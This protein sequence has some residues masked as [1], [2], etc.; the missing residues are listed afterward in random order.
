MHAASRAEHVAILTAPL[1]G[2]LNPIQAVGA[3]LT[4]LGWRVSVVHIAAA[5]PLVTHPSIAFAALA[6]DS[7]AVFAA[8]LAALARPSGPIGLRRM[9]RTT[10]AMTDRL[11]AQAPAVLDRIGAT[12][13]LADA[14]EPAGPLIARRLGL[15]CAIALTGLPLLGDEL[16][17]PPYVGWRFR[18]D[19]WGRF[20]NRSG[21]AVAR[22]LMRP[23]EAVVQARR[24]AWG[25][26]DAPPMAHVQ[27]AQCPREL[28]FP[29]AQL[30][31]KFHYG[32]P[33]RLPESTASEIARDE[34][35]LIFCSLGTLQGARP[36]LFAI[37]AAACAAIGARAV[38][39]HGGGLTPE[40]EAALPGD[41]LV[42]AFWPQRAVLDQCDAAI[43][44]GGFNSVLDALAAGVPI[45]AL[46][47]GFEQPGTAARIAHSGA[48]KVLSPHRLSTQSLAHALGELIGN[49]RYR[50][51]ARR[52]AA[53]MR[54]GD[55]ADGAA[56][57]IDAA[58]T[59][60]A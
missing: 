44:H 50:S 28:D 20:R 24:S 10:A 54:A 51:A 26:H 22:Q 9:I 18:T 31:A 43:L 32:S 39:G 52:L 48:G 45:V 49:D 5:R 8:Y 37:M 1:P 41:P 55:G 6:D 7:E 27:V 33:W 30:P 23:I 12:A 19:A 38:I 2:H 57:V 42:R 36:A 40:E 46:P 53:T 29:R 47:I 25:L 34:R 4:A 60:R 17:P 58:L 15:P 56:A 35:P 11:L 21:Y 3:R 59:S 16:I 14:V 13:V